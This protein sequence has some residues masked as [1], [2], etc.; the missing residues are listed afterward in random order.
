MANND[1][2][3]NLFGGVG[4]T[5]DLFST[6]GKPT[7][8]S[9][10]DETQKQF[11]SLFKASNAA[12]QTVNTGIDAAAETDK[13]LQD[14]QRV[15][16]ELRKGID[17]SNEAFLK[18]QQSLLQDAQR[19][20]QQNAK[21]Y[22]SY[23]EEQRKAE[24]NRKKEEAKKRKNLIDALLKNPDLLPDVDFEAF[25]ESPEYLNM[26]TAQ[27][28]DEVPKVVGEYVSLLESRIASTLGFP[29][30]KIP[31]VENWT[32]DQIAE[33]PK[34][35]EQ[36]LKLK[37]LTQ[38][39]AD[40]LEAEMMHRMNADTKEI[41][42]DKSFVK[43]F[44]TAAKV[45]WEQQDLNPLS[46]SIESSVNL[47]RAVQN[48]GIV[49][50]REL[51]SAAPELE[52]FAFQIADGKGN[53]D[54]SAIDDYSR[55]Q[56][57]N[58]LNVNRGRTVLRANKEK[59]DIEKA[60]E[61][62][63]ARI[64][65]SQANFAYAKA[66]DPNYADYG[67]WEEAKFGF[68]H[69]FKEDMYSTILPSVPSIAV[70]VGSS[71]ASGAAGGAVFGPAGSVAGGLLGGAA[72]GAQLTATD[73]VN[74]TIEMID[75]VPVDI[76]AQRVPN[77]NEYL[78]L[79]NGD[80]QRAK[81]LLMYSAAGEQREW[82]YLI[83][84]GLGLVDP[85]TIL[86]TA[87]SK[88]IA[89]MWGA[90]A[91]S[92]AGK[93][94]ARQASGIT[95]KGLAKGA[96]KFGGATVGGGIQES[97]EEGLTAYASNYGAY[98][99]GV[100]DDPMKGVGEAAGVAFGIG[101]IFGGSAYGIGATGSAI[102]T[103]AV[104]RDGVVRVTPE[105]AAEIYGDVTRIVGGIR[106]EDLVQNGRIPMTTLKKSIT[107]AFAKAEEATEAE[108]SNQNLTQ[109]ERQANA[110][111]RKQLI[112]DGV[113]SI[114]S[115]TSRMTEENVGQITELANR[116]GL[117]VNPYSTA[118]WT[119]DM[120]AFDSGVLNNAD[121]L[122]VA[123]HDIDNNRAVSVNVSENLAGAALAVIDAVINSEINN[124]G[125]TTN[126]RVQAFADVIGG[127]ANA[128]GLTDDETQQLQR[129]AGQRLN[130]NTHREGDPNGQ[131]ITTRYQAQRQAGGGGNRVRFATTN[132]GNNTQGAGNNAQAQGN[133]ATTGTQAAG[134]TT[135]GAQRNATT[136]TQAG[137]TGTNEVSPTEATGPVGQVEGEGAVTG[138]QEGQSSR[139][140]GPSTEEET[141]SGGGTGVETTGSGANDQRQG[142]VGAGDSWDSITPQQRTE[143]EGRAFNLATGTAALD[144]GTGSVRMTREQLEALVG[145][146]LAEYGVDYTI[147][148]FNLASSAAWR[149]GTTAEQF[150]AELDSISTILNLKYG[151]R[152]EQQGPTDTDA[153]TGSTDA[154]DGRGAEATT[155][156][157]PAAELRADQTQEIGGEVTPA[158]ELREMAEGISESPVVSTEV[159]TRPQDTDEVATNNRP[160][161][162]QEPVWE[163]DLPSP[164]KIIHSNVTAQQYAQELINGLP[165][166]TTRE[167]EIRT[168]VASVEPARATDANIARRDIER[169][170][171]NLELN[172][173]READFINN[174]RTESTESLDSVTDTW[175]DFAGQVGFLYVDNGE[176]RLSLPNGTDIYVSDVSDGETLAD[177]DIVPVN[178]SKSLSDMNSGLR[179]WLA[180]DEDQRP[181]T[182]QT[183]INEFLE[184]S[185]RASDERVAQH[186]EDARALEDLIQEEARLEE[187][188][189][190]D[191]EH[192]AVREALD[193]IYKELYRL[194]FDEAGATEYIGAMVQH[195][196]SGRPLNNPEMLGA[197]SVKNR[198]GGNV[199]R[200]QVR[201]DEVA[202]MSSL[203][204]ANAIYDYVAE[205]SMFYEGQR[206]GAEQALATA[207]NL[208]VDMGYTPDEALAE[209]QT[210]AQDMALYL[211]NSPRDEESRVTARDE[212]YDVGN[213]GIPPISEDAADA[214]L[215]VVQNEF[216][217]FQEEMADAQPEIEAVQQDNSIETEAIAQSL[218]RDVIDTI[219]NIMPWIANPDS[220]RRMRGWISDLFE[221]TLDTPETE[222]SLRASYGTPSAE[223]AVR[224]EVANLIKGNEPISELI[225]TITGSQTFLKAL[226]DGTSVMSGMLGEER[227]QRLQNRVEIAINSM[228]DFV[229]PNGEPTPPGSFPDYVIRDRYDSGIRTSES[230]AIQAVHSAIRRAADALPVGAARSLNSFVN[231]RSER[232]QVRLVDLGLHGEEPL[233]VI[234]DTALRDGNLD[235]LE[236][237]DFQFIP[238]GA[239]KALERVYDNLTREGSEFNVY[240]AV[241]DAIDYELSAADFSNVTD[242]FLGNVGAFSVNSAE[243]SVSRRLEIRER[244]RATELRDGG[245]RQQTDE[246][247]ID[248]QL[249][250]EQGVGQADEQLEQTNEQDGQRQALRRDEDVQPRAERLTADET[251]STANQ[252][253]QQTAL[254]E[255]SVDQV[256]DTSSEAAATSVES[257]AEEATAKL[258]PQETGRRK[259]LTAK[260]DEAPA[261]ASMT[262]ELDKAGVTPKE[263]SESIEEAT[264]VPESD[265]QMDIF[266]ENSTMKETSEAVVQDA[267]D[268][269][270]PAQ[271]AF[272]TNFANA[273]LH[274]KTRKEL[275]IGD[276]KDAEQAIV[277]A[278]AADLELGFLD[279]EFWS[280]TS[281]GFKKAM[282]AVVDF[283]KSSAMSIAF[284][285]MLGLA[286][287]SPNVNLTSQ[288]MAD[289]GPT[290]VTVA[291]VIPSV[292][293]DANVARNYI[294]ENSHAIGK[295]Y[296]IADK[297]AGAVYL[298]DANHNYLS[299]APALFGAN[300]SDAK[301]SGSTPA[302]RFS[303]SYTK[304]DQAPSYGGSIQV[305]D[306]MPTIKD[307]VQEVFAMHRVINMPGEGRKGRLQSTTSADNR[308]S[309]GCINV[310]ASF[311]DNHFDGNFD[312]F[313]YVIPE[314][315]NY[316]GNTFG[317]NPGGE[318]DV[319][320]T[321]PVQVQKAE[322]VEVQKGAPAEDVVKASSDVVV[323]GV[324]PQGGG[325]A[326]ATPLSI[327]GQDTNP[328]NP[329][330]QVEPTTVNGITYT[331]I[332]EPD[333]TVAPDDASPNEHFNTKPIPSSVT[334]D[335]G[336]SIFD[337][338]VGVFGTIM[339]GAAASAG[340]GRRRR[341][342]SASGSQATTG[343]TTTPPAGGGTPP[344]R[345][346]T[347]GTPQGALQTIVT[348][349]NANNAS[350]GGQNVPVPPAVQNAMNLEQIQ[351]EATRRGWFNYVNAISNDN[352]AVPMMVLSE[353]MWG[354][355]NAMT[356]TSINYSIEEGGQQDDWKFTRM[357]GF[358]KYMRN[359]GGATIELDKLA[360]MMHS[361][362]IGIEA[363]ASIVSASLASMKGRQIGIQ[364]VMYRNG[365]EKVEHMLN[366][367]ASRRGESREQI[368]QD[369]G[370]Y[371]NLYHYSEEGIDHHMY[372]LRREGIVHRD[373]MLAAQQHLDV[374]ETNGDTKSAEY[375]QT[376]AAYEKSKSA[377]RRAQNEYYEVLYAVEGPQEAARIQAADLADA[378]QQMANE[379][380][381]KDS[382]AEDALSHM[383][384]RL[385]AA[386]TRISELDAM[387]PADR[388]VPDN[389]PGGLSREQTETHM[390]ELEARY[391]DDAL[392]QSGTSLLDV[393]NAIFSGSRFN[394]DYAYA[395]GVFS[396]ADMQAFGEVNDGRPFQYYVPMWHGQEATNELGT[397]DTFSDVDQF[398][399][400]LP[401]GFV[402]R[403]SLS[404]VYT[405][406]ERTFIERVGLAKDITSFSRQGSRTRPDNAVVNLRK[407]MN[408]LASRAGERAF[409]FQIE[410]MFENNYSYTDENGN[411]IPIQ[412]AEDAQAWYQQL[413]DQSANG[414][415]QA[416]R[417]EAR[418][419]L[420]ALDSPDGLQPEGRRGLV[421][422]RPGQPVP[423]NVTN[424]T[425]I[426][427][428]GMNSRGQYVDYRY[429]FVDPVV[430]D[431]VKA[432]IGTYAKPQYAV[433]SALRKTTGIMA[434]MMT[435]MRPLWNIF[436][437]FQ[438]FVEY[439]GNMMFR[440]ALST[441]GSVVSNRALAMRFAAEASRASAGIADISNAVA[442]SDMNSHYGRLYQELKSEG[443]IHVFQDLVNM[444]AERAFNRNDPN[445]T[446]VERAK[447]RISQTMDKNAV[448]S[449][450]K[451]LASSAA[452][453]YNQRLVETL[454][455]IPVIATFEALVNSGVN[456]AEAHRITR[457][458]YDPLRNAQHMGWMSSLYAFA[459][460]AKAGGYNLARNLTQY[461]LKGFGATLS[462]ITAFGL[463]H[464]IA[465]MFGDDDDEGVPER[466]SE[467]LYTFTRG[468]GITVDENGGKFYVPIGHGVNKVLATI[469]GIAYKAFHG[470]MD[471]SEAALGFASV[472]LDNA[473][474]VQVA[475]LSLIMEDP[476]AWA[477]LSATPTAL[478]PFAESTLG[479][480]AFTGRNL[481][482]YPTPQGQNKADRDNFYTKQWAKDLAQF[483]R[484]DAPLG[485]DVKPETIQ[486]LVESNAIGP[487]AIFKVLG[488][489]VAQ[490]TQGHI[491][492]NA[493]NTPMWWTVMGGAFYDPNAAQPYR[494]A[495]AIKEK[496]K[497]LQKSYPGITSTAE[498][499]LKE[500][501]D[502]AGVTGDDRK[503]I[504]NTIEY[505][506]KSRKLKDAFKEAVA[507]VETA[508]EGTAKY[509]RAL[510]A[511]DRIGEEL[512]QLD[513]RYYEENNEY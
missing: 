408:N 169:Q 335:D 200:R 321:Q 419:T 203:E 259:K 344:V 346:P 126:Q 364:S 170:V 72:G 306:K 278:A 363:D 178:S 5:S 244:A 450:V 226:A 44:I 69:G 324:A 104:N 107:E 199:A 75:S 473:S 7:L 36:L 261:E 428:K 26:P 24:E 314:T 207:A 510:R 395:N 369:F 260:N 488:N 291:E 439:G 193:E 227:L 241:E 506:K 145:D 106:Q 37:E 305:F 454:Q 390:R 361:P 100:I 332:S 505:E 297:Q 29:E 264:Q 503:F 492:S 212:N 166:L 13:A 23:L 477:G 58:A 153:Q 381:A 333:N 70:S 237:G 384:N 255:E 281:N 309:N 142:T 489:D 412:T 74:S 296:V 285:S 389:M 118:G 195:L 21:N 272:I 453:A 119:T 252:E 340:L 235:F 461:G 386:G 279:S 88:P 215:G 204:L 280:K 139:L 156:P 397:T 208:L 271:R 448:T 236:S 160:D 452:E 286:A 430:N 446:R 468:F 103:F 134:Q 247:N 190:A 415:T 393:A 87:A 474:P 27:R 275:G 65:D 353:L 32:L 183:F 407:Q 504:E 218:T 501:L 228:R 302:G 433:T 502:A 394:V 457:D 105:E 210:M 177:L 225:G 188:E 55:E 295:P 243:Q 102:S 382:Y 84:G 438:T 376:R 202:E 359:M 61:G 458:M 94:A 276:G 144:Q 434:A 187:Q 82:G 303:L 507:D 379:N 99:A 377:Y 194:G 401:D 383:V 221:G 267:I 485:L 469:A 81:E 470:R 206:A 435:H 270:P 429:Y 290:N 368:E 413:A 337:L 127:I 293:Q 136:P 416:E 31:D 110:R 455:V 85:G 224:L 499:K 482:P 150:A 35:Y 288:A 411:R 14:A 451:N 490:K 273:P 77:W 159:T 484:Y 345:L 289:T 90:T 338:A 351:S 420:T 349:A 17:A 152:D 456:R 258:T 162:F 478:E 33:D 316:T 163:I 176:Y 398:N 38:T 480:D 336:N 372:K 497:A 426:R 422:V 109:E 342:L 214:T 49:S 421:R 232:G 406:V 129:Y 172:A 299:Q 513:I 300:V 310:P 370:D 366:R 405:D 246:G 352:Q 53:I 114:N 20:N 180:L 229:I 86:G 343:A 294:K 184:N 67:A 400:A 168:A 148:F 116:H 323:E 98:K 282:R 460:S 182:A 375:N 60:E 284:V 423:A 124:P 115:L 330:T 464:A 253:Q 263:V 471:G 155:Q 311:Y 432:A 117:N 417:D 56:I 234:M 80:P 147:E 240:Q 164:Y 68:E 133:T 327:S 73:V 388:P 2:L 357:P 266:S 385:R 348:Q 123:A 50:A 25:F 465:G 9:A 141:G 122:T 62:Y 205:Q 440:R 274:N 511:V 410:R 301:T 140:S 1:M 358:K 355:R 47:G 362:T 307:G 175:V 108:R 250:S 92:V 365:L 308:I 483:L 78:S 189:R 399:Q 11:Q 113:M 19:Q 213:Y 498:D 256:A 239:K 51:A 403:E 209:A 186:E 59:A 374:L 436:N 111:A 331:E 157:R 476:I 467:P 472:L 222:A 442:G 130:I 4:S 57:E 445:V 475:N 249:E 350:S 149:E 449:G 373:I 392:R 459:N 66:K 509:R 238:E 248:E 360:K 165:N 121:D 500:Q 245:A 242:S 43:D 378:Q 192:R 425:P 251:N 404:D 41:R 254:T 216:N 135:Q 120:V 493:D 154:G 322:A 418:A 143:L 71:A 441:D 287:M 320:Y 341:R 137:G 427:A 317:V 424:H 409:T 257:Y 125:M 486:H 8:D 495:S 197:K 185:Q 174:R 479:Y 95:A 325:M 128:R 191:A 217:L 339:G 312:G 233:T 487:L 508:E 79:A 173:R 198:Y 132:T 18:N 494:R 46:Q 512:K 146:M 315:T 292:S 277:E 304:Y 347:G 30:G 34:A 181:A 201:A 101:G 91:A 45:A 171:Y 89:K 462:V 167:L 93:A 22:A 231:P 463:A 10:L 443:T 447:A 367:I 262:Q 6:S 97:F 54:I 319:K 380:P 230:K 28:A 371:A 481:A 334:D 313:L 444:K 12:A 437:A 220:V 491:A 3:K 196:E 39:A 402:D 161:N 42:N 265:A 64:K 328:F 219:M 268:K 223:Y 63:S 496:A 283:I 391:D 326:S 318:P 466:A 396:A 96:L 211:G 40:D 112:Y 131:A 387:P 269:L 76:L 138:D 158:T 356:D 16:S 329:A 151:V 15:N 431:D 179:N 52:S 414:A 354:L 83:G 298:F 48:G